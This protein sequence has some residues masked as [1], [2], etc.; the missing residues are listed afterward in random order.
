MTAAT[1]ADALVERLVE[2]LDRYRVFVSRAAA[3]ELLQAESAEEL[4]QIMG[5]LRLPPYAWR[6]DVRLW[7]RARSAR[8]YSRE[9]LALLHPHLFADAAEWVKGHVR[10]IGHRGARP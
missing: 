9:E 3:G 5:T 1:V 4:S 2:R 8:Q 7:A 10:A 6:R